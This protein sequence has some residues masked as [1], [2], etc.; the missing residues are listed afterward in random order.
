MSV[1]TIIIVNWNGKD[2]LPQCLRSIAEN[3]P[4]VSF[5][6]VVVDNLSADGS[7]EWLVS[8]E[9]EQIFPAG[10]FRVILSD[11]NLGF[12][13]ANNLAIDS[14]DSEYLFLLNPDTIVKLDAIDIL[15]AVLKGERA[16][17]AV[18]PKLL[19]EDGST[20]YS[21]WG[22]PP[23]PLSLLVQGLQFDS[24]LP[25]QLLQT[26]L[27]ASHWSYDRRAAVPMFSGAAIAAKR[28]MIDMVG[29]F[30]PDFHMYGEDGE[31]CVRMNRNGWLTVFEPEAVI[32]HLGGQSSI[33]RWGTDDSRIKEQEAFIYFQ[34][35]CLPRVCVFSNLITRLF[36]FSL[37]YLRNIVLRRDNRMTRE[38]LALHIIAIRDL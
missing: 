20:Q 36:I 19:N 29:A 11:E 24:L 7:R 1:L 30:D 32:V 17:G 35:K 8:E 26:W 34:K 13:R 5:E 18:A 37:Y 22:F 23:T 25:K 31:W 6:V 38:I 21:V 9:A 3:P 28:E 16:I 27:Y 4:S 12:G 14:T 2:F 10:S 15:L 33:Q